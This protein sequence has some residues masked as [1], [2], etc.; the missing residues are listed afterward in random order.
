MRLA[1][2][3]VALAATVVVAGYAGAGIAAADPAPTPAPTPGPAHAPGPGPAPGP[4]PGSAPAAK[5]VIDADGSYTVGTDI[6]PG[7]Y[8]SE[9]PVGDSACYWK[10]VNG[11]KIVDN[12][13]SKKPQTVT[14]EPTDTVFKTDRCKPWQ[15]TDCEAGCAPAQPPPDLPGDLRDI[16]GQLPQPPAPGGR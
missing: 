10:R 3:P 9:G 6:L 1:N 11:D 5:T 13:L 8:R 4:A 7:T 2:V 14:I 15:K 12:A 16:F